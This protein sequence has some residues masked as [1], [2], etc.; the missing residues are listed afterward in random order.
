[1][2]IAAPDLRPW[3]GGDAGLPGFQTRHG[4]ADFVAVHQ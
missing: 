1:V 3:I 4:A 2:R